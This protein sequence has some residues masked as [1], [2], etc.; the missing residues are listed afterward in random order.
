MGAALTSPRGDRPLGTVVGLTNPTPRA[1]GL[2]PTP[3]RAARESAPVMNFLGRIPL[4]EWAT[5]PRG[6]EV[7]APDSAQARRS[8]I[9][10]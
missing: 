8:G 10:F 4:G 3:T 2:S 9:S 5:I 6:L 1:P 7:I